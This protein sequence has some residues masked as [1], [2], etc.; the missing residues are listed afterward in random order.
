VKVLKMM[1][2][3]E[4]MRQT[5]LAQGEEK[6][7]VSAAVARLH[8]QLDRPGQFRSAVQELEPWLMRETAAAAAAGEGGNV[9][10]ARSN[11]TRA[12]LDLLK[13]WQATMARTEAA[14]ELL[15]RCVGS[16]SADVTAA[17]LGSEQTQQ[18]RGY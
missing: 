17:L 13:E 11:W 1:S 3:I 10:N 16:D 8:Q 15:A 9:K 4:S 14:I 2:M 12:Q 5:N 6:Q 18:H 7:T